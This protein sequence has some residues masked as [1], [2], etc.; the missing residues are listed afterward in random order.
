M[1]DCI[2]F[3]IY[4]EGETSPSDQGESE[5]LNDTVN[6]SMANTTIEAEITQDSVAM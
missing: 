1:S 3:D 2:K 6:D 4:S 5:G